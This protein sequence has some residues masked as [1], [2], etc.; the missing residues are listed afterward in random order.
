MI[1][2]ADIMTGTGPAA[3]V[4]RKSAGAILAQLCTVTGGTSGEDSRPDISTTRPV[5]IATAIV[6]S[7]RMSYLRVGPRHG[8][9]SSAATALRAARSRQRTRLAGSGWLTPRTRTSST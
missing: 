8:A 3:V 7:L 5:V 6:P 4:A 2:S 1:S 9:V